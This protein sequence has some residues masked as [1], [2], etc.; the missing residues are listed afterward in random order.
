MSSKSIRAID[1]Y[2]RVSNW[3]NSLQNAHPDEIER[4]T[5]ERDKALT[6]FRKAFRNV[7][8]AEFI[9]G[10]WNGKDIAHRIR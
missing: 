1:L 6:R 3:N 8:L 4:W 10:R 9:D 7:S 2:C 5:K